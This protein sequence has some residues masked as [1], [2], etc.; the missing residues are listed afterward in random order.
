[1]YYIVI[2]YSATQDRGGEDG[3]IGGGGGGATPLK[4]R[5][6]FFGGGGAKKQMRT[7]GKISQIVSLCSISELSSRVC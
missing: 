2:D 7:E 3:G 6:E 5:S 4:L 1:M